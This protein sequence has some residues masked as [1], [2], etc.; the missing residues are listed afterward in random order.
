MPA[1]AQHRVTRRERLRAETTR[2]I[3]AIA[4]RQLA[5]GGAGAISLRGIAREMGM[6]ARA[7]YTYFP[8]RDDLITAL[9]DEISTS[10]ANSLER[11]RD[12]APADD[13]GARL[14]AWGVALREWALAHPD[15]FRLIYGDPVPGYQPPAN[16]P[17]DQAARRVCGGLNRLVAALSGSAN[18]PDGAEWSDF[19]PAYVAKVRAEAPE[20]SPA[21][22][23]LA[24]RVWG[25]IHGL[26]TLEIYG[27]LRSV[28]NDPAALQ[29]AD[30]H[31][32]VGQLHG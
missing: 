29:R 6:T 8:T 17:T 12:G 13:P 10:L 16:G 20:L 3:M 14:I 21:V 19:P 25:R 4:L 27:H 23:A 2:E 31:D 9:T 26:V 30:L 24:L 1:T 18:G 32:L 22:A 5:T 28:S 7:I 15:G 11:A